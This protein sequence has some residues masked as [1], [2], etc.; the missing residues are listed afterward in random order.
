MNYLLSAIFGAAGIACFIWYKPLYRIY[1]QFMAKGYRDQ[2]GKLAQKM[3]WDDPEN[4]GQIIIYKGGII[5]LGIFFLAMAFHFAFG[6]I[7]IG[8]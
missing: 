6:T 1:A 5:A 4:N 2:F 7:H 8:E 3:G